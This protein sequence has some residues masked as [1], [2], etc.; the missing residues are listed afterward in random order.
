[1]SFSGQREATLT[2]RTF[3]MGLLD[4]QTGKVRVKHVPHVQRETLQA[5]VREQVEPGSEV[6]TDEWMPIAARI[7]S[8][9]ITSS[10]TRKRMYRATST[11]TGLRTSG[12]F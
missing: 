4:H 10:T 7:A 8:M 3:S 9:S 6:L 12:C 5:E 11:R 2:F 1:M